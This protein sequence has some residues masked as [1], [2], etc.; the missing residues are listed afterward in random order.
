MKSV[1]V[2]S[3]LIVLS[4]FI[5]ELTARGILQRAKDV[6]EVMKHQYVQQAI[7]NA[8]HVPAAAKVYMNDTAADTVNSYSDKYHQF[9]QAKA[10]VSGKYHAGKSQSGDATEQLKQKQQEHLKQWKDNYENTKETAYEDWR[11]L[12][13]RKSAAQVKNPSQEA[14]NWGSKLKRAA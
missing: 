10:N 1:Y 6:G 5:S 7:E 8:K 2:F 13:T 12:S 9:Y 11:L 3:F 14:K 4:L